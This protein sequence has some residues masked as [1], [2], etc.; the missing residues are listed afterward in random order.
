M[1]SS[2]L[3][4]KVKTSGKKIAKILFLLGIR[5]SYLFSRNL[6]GMTEH[7]KLTMGRIVNQRDLS[8]G[9]LFFGLPVS[10]WFGWLLVLL[11]SRLFIFGR[12]HFGFWAKASFLASTLFTSFCLLVI[13][14]C[15]YAVWKK[16]RRG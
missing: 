16:G 8:Q 14:S 9:L 4:L 5:E 6:Y 15:F 3:K 7:P 1:Q 2:K 10:L 12:L 11:V 13:A